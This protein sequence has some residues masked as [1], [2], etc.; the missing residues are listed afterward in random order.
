MQSHFLPHMGFFYGYPTVCD[1]SSGEA[2][3]FSYVCELTVYARVM[4]A[5]RTTEELKPEVFDHYTT[6]DESLVEHPLVHSCWED[7]GIDRGSSDVEKTRLL[8]SYLAENKHF[9]KTKDSC[10]CDQCSTLNALT[11]G[12][13]PLYYVSSCLYYP[14]SPAKN[15]SPRAD[16]SHSGQPTGVEP[17]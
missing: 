2:Y 3:T 10:Q 8:Y 6:V 4:G 9:K 16:R 13:W 5:T 15:T 14:L 11:D 12:R 17:V 1:F 7:V